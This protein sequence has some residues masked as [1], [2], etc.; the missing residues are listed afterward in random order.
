MYK[1][2]SLLFPANFLL[3]LLD[4]SPDQGYTRNVTRKVIGSDGK[5]YYHNYFVMNENDLIEANIK[6]KLGGQDF[7][8][9]TT[10]ILYRNEH[11][12]I[13]A[14]T[15]RS[16]LNV[17]GGVHMHMYQEDVDMLLKSGQYVYPSYDAAEYASRNDIGPYKTDFTG[18]PRYSGEVYTSEEMYEIVR[19]ITSPNPEEHMYGLCLLYTSPSP[20]D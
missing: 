12:E 19:Y 4:D 17:G 15:Y 8:D 20:R 13:M 3:D 18:K 6:E 14:W 2:Q 11:Q 16:P 5:T 9:K 1:R 7:D 10:T